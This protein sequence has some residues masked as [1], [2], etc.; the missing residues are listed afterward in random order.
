MKKNEKLTKELNEAVEKNETYRQVV[1][2]MMQ[3]KT[4]FK[5]SQNEWDTDKQTYEAEINHL[6]NE[7]RDLQNK[8]N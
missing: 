5:K 7:I 4:I 3:L 8:K 1:N 6:K 2:D